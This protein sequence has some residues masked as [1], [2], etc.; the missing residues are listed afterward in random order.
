MDEDTLQRSLRA[1]PP[2]DPI[3][4]SRFDVAPTS[5]A[6]PVRR[7]PGDPTT[8]GPS[9]MFSATRV[10]AAIV[11]VLSASG[12]FFLAGG[13]RPAPVGT[14]A[15]PSPSPIRGLVTEPVVPVVERVI[16][17]GFR[18]FDRP[19]DTSM[20]KTA[21]G[22]D[23][24]IW[25]LETDR[26]FRVGEPETYSRDGFELR[27]E[28]NWIPG[29]DDGIQVARDGTL[30]TEAWPVRSFD[31][32][33][34]RTERE[35]YLFPGQAHGEIWAYS[36]SL[37]ARWDGDV[38][39]EFPV[40]GWSGSPWPAAA[41]SD[42][43]VWMGRFDADRTSDV[44]YLWRLG[45][46]DGATVDDMSIPGIPADASPTLIAVGPDDT[47]WVYLWTRSGEGHLAR[48]TSDGW[49]IFHAEDGVPVVVDFYQGALGF[50]AVG[51]DGSVWLT[52]RSP[53]D[54]ECG[55]IASFDGSVWTSYLQDACIVDL[56]V[57][58]DGT[59]WVQTAV[60]GTDAH[61]A[62]ST[63]RITPVDAR[64]TTTRGGPE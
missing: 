24:T 53:Q 47:L 26:L 12:V 36:G 43:V 27:D 60:P 34:W 57:A 2:A 38:W 16:G 10:V 41:T 15:S 63:Y 44:G 56:D 35:G 58:P 40:P 32:S 52:P 6:R 22:P 4:Q 61:V 50:M 23:G 5:L 37:I 3:Y 28:P 25:M 31:G 29:F 48:L 55:G 7:L 18:L 33:T 64:A 17:D 21:I 45:R 9:A 49:T 20:N 51:P 59:V 54:A 46:F 39:V 14:A 13:S 1:R 42:G 11:I 19:E 8:R 62:A 30:F